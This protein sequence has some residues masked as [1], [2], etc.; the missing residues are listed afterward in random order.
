MNF[1][2]TI[3]QNIKAKSNTGSFL[4]LILLLSVDFIYIILHFI[5]QRTIPVLRSVLFDLQEDGGYAEVFQ[6][7]KYVWIILLFMYI[8]KSTKCFNYISWILLYMYFLCDDVF[9]LHVVLGESVSKSFHF[10][11]PFNLRLQDIGELV[12]SIAAGFVLAPVLVFAFLRGSQMF[13]KIFMDIFL[14]TVAF[15]FFG[16][17]MDMA[18]SAIKLGWVAEQGLGIIEDGGEMITL[19]LI[20]WYIFNLATNKGYSNIFLFDLPYLKD[21]RVNNNKK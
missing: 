7:I 16:V 9:K 2:N 6:Y 1:L 11:A 20:L 10:I 4:L 14:L 13:K 5:H 21:S 15:V 18:D 17:F 12:I 19:S 8:L 3:F